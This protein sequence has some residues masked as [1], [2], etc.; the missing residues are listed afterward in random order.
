LLRA[1]VARL[2]AKYR[3][4]L[5]LRYFEGLSRTEC[6][7]LL[8]IPEETVKTRL[9]RGRELLRGRLHPRLRHALWL[10][11]WL[12]A[13]TAAAAP[14][15][16]VVMKTK[17]GIIVALLALLGLVV[18][19]T[20]ALRSGDTES[21]PRADSQLPREA[22]ADP[23]KPAPNPDLPGESLPELRETFDLSVA[24]RDR[25]V[26]GSVV[27]EDG[28]SVAGAQLSLVRHPWRRANT[29]NV[30]QHHA[31]VSGPQVL[32]ARDGTFVLP[33]KR[34]RI[35][36]LRVEAEGLARR[37]IDD[38]QAGERLRIVM[39]PGCIVDVRVVGPDEVEL[40][41]VELVLRGGAGVDPEPG[42]RRATTGS[43]GRARFESVAG[44]QG[45]WIEAQHSEYGRPG[46]AR[47]QAPGAG[48]VVRELIRM[49][50]RRTVTGRVTDSETGAPIANAR[51][52]LHWLQRHR[53]VTDSDGRYALSAWRSDGMLSIVAS[54]SGYGF[55]QTDL[56]A[57]DELDFVLERGDRVTGRIVDDAGKPVPGVRVAAL[58]TVMRE[59]TLTSRGYASSGPDGAFAIDGLRH[60]AIHT[61][62]FLKEG[63]GRMLRD[64]DPP[65]RAGGQVE[66]GDVVLWPGR[67]IETPTTSAASGSPISRPAP[68]SWR[69]AVPTVR[70]RRSR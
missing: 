34:G 65:A 11:P 28:S 32:S 62:A 5:V 8:E 37:R 14:A 53:V 35:G 46:W 69:R 9:R 17:A 18:V 22:Q 21:T 25:D 58:G 68:T 26:H 24:D 16:G 38:V 52:G 12:L 47:I 54:A 64:I 44:N 20:N 29:L 41:G 70:R 3:D 13:D 42:A 40:S 1:E 56:G 48:Q 49:R 19:G 6:A 31:A 51:V 2:P 60:D 7:A 10:G 4:V 15:M 27:R 63:F 55:E 33:W 30:D 66:M 23:S 45:Y 67:S 57:G 39:G 61:V 43:D 59:R 50:L 36:E